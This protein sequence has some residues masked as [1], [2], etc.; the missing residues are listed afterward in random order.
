MLTL[1][2]ALKISREV[3]SNIYLIRSVT[4]SQ[5]FGGYNTIASPFNYRECLGIDIW[6]M[7]C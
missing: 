7:N 6:L 1:L 5:S 3:I 4:V 2:K